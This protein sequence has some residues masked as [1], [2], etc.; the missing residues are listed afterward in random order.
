VNEKSQFKFENARQSIGVQGHVLDSIQND[1]LIE[2]C[3]SRKML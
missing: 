1:K 2:H 3:K